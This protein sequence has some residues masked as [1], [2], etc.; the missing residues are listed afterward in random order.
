MKTATW[1]SRTTFLFATISCS[2]GLGNMWRFPYVAGENGGGAFVLV[3]IGFVLLIGIPLIMAE[4]AI[5]R[6]G[7]SN[8]IDTTATISMAESGHSRWQL[9]G[10]LSIIAPLIALSFYGVV[11]GWSLEYLFFAATDQFSGISGEE[12]ELMFAGVLAAPG[13]MLFFFS[14]VIASVA[15][16]V[17]SG[18]RSGIERV[19]KIMM[20]AL[21]IL[22]VGLAGYAIKVGDPGA[23]VSFLFQPDFSMLT[24]QG[25]LIAF[26]QSM[27]SLAVGTG[28]LLAYG[29]YLPADTSIPGAAWTI[30]LA[31]T[32]AAMLAGML[33]FPIVFASGLDPA[34]GPGLIFVILPM[35]FNEMPGGQLFGSLFFL[36]IFFAAYTSGLG[37]MEPFVS[38]L[39]DRPNWTRRRAAL[40]AGL[41][42]WLLGLAAVFSFNLW[43]N[44]TPLDMIPQMEG[45]TVF[46][47][48]DYVTSNLVLPIN[49]LMLALMAGWV[50]NNTRMRQDIGIQQD[51][52]WTIWKYAIRYLAPVAILCMFVVNLL[53]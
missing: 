48:L 34:E 45:R 8:P 24:A 46:S 18:V 21:F 14:L 19:S 25:V 23:A 41:M 5:A 4:L 6:R 38:W 12:A 16:V 35:A 3:Y 39:E 36:L 2:V 15:L 52:S 17:G 22:L 29:A 40:S 10:W 53:E 28:A 1:S 26:G 44:F 11:A 49:A 7:R 37:M 30:G 47:I 27:F 20:P 50:I 43:K 9:I 32:S 13:R 33:I 31:D 51:F 42:I